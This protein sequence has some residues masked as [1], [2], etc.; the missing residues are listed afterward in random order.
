MKNF[1]ISTNHHKLNLKV[2]SH[3]GVQSRFECLPKRTFQSDDHRHMK[4]EKTFLRSNNFLNYS[5]KPCTKEG[6]ITYRIIH[7]SYV[8][9][10]FRRKRKPRVTFD[11]VLSVPL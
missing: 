4:D 10:N 3:D 6:L 5:I 8:N 1:G 9:Y 2:L 11:R 7:F